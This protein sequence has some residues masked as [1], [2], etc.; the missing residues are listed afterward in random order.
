MIFWLTII[1]YALP[2]I[3]LISF[4]RF[5]LLHK[6]TKRNNIKFDL[7]ELTVIIPFRNEE[8]N[9]PAI[10][11]C[12]NNSTRLPLKFIFIDDH[13]TD[14]SLD[15]LKDLSVNNTD[16]HVVRLQ[17]NL[18]G[19]KHALRLGVG[20]AKTKYVLFLDAD[21]HFDKEYFENLTTIE[22]GDL[23][24]LPVKM[25]STQWYQHFFIIDYNVVNAVNEAIAGWNRPIMA[26]GAN[27]LIAREKFMKWDSNNHFNY[28]GGDD[29]YIL[30][31]FRKNNG[32][33]LLESNKKYCVQTQGPNSVKEFISQRLRWI[34]NS[35]KV[36]DNLSDFLVLLQLVLTFSYLTTFFY[37]LFHTLVEEALWLAC[38]K[39][40]F[41]IL[42]FY[43]FFKN[44]E[45]VLPLCL[46]P[47]YELLFPIY[48][49]ILM[50][51][52]IFIKPKWKNRN[53]NP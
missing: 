39:F 7:K 13:S 38:F 17:D 44:K 41:D 31:D 52:M 46:L 27:L 40:I 50:I 35:K 37:F 15:Y 16:I 20:L 22:T 3:L 18:F 33:I 19:K 25:I 5:Q 51:G 36:S 8:T 43:P 53:I 4:G 6:K 48:V 21:V 24:I 42:L 14:S 49:L 2:L 23:N 26:S 32:Q 1:C 11:K 12:I 29:L 10:V 9:L 28:L 34:N 47:I 45:Q 30:R